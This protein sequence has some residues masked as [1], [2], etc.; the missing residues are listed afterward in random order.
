MLALNSGIPQYNSKEKFESS[1]GTHIVPRL[2]S[3]IIN[4][5]ND[6]SINYHIDHPVKFSLV[7][8]KTIRIKGWIVSKEVSVERICIFFN[9]CIIGETAPNISRKR[10]SEI[11]SGYCN[12]SKPGFDVDISGIAD[13]ELLLKACLDNERYV[14]IVKFNIETKSCWQNKILYIHIPKTG[15]SSVNKFISSHFRSDEVL[16]HAESAPGWNNNISE[17]GTAFISGHIRYP[18][19]KDLLGSL[20]D[21]LKV[22]TLR[23]P[24]SHVI[25]HLAWVRRLSD[26][27]QEARFANHPVPIQDLSRKLANID[28]GSPEY[29]SRFISGM[30]KHERDLMDNTQSR[31]LSKVTPGSS[32]SD[33]DISLA[34]KNIKEFDV[35]GITERMDNFIVSLSEKAGWEIPGM[36]SAPK[37]N[38]LSEKYGMDANDVKFVTALMP[39]IR[40][41]MELYD[42][43]G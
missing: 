43:L 42:S 26:P 13:G 29:I 34:R 41:D 19:F 11:F 10:A 39:L 4:C 3:Q 5:L 32:V 17:K 35:I 40:Y 24:V 1:K 6:K 23:N 9:G 30:N 28:L 20:D 22:V 21:Y 8:D 14:N 18:V 37:I 27:G 7:R 33:S 31:Y 38:V 36:N 16:T 25:S 12:A 2:V 15:G